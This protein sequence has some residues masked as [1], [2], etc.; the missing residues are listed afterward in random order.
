MRPADIQDIPTVDPETL[1]LQFTPLI[2]KTAKRYT[3]ALTHNN[4]VDE[5]DLIQA[6]RIAILKAQ[7]KYDPD[8]GAS[9]L[10]YA[11]KWIRSA[12]RRTIGYQHDGSLPDLPISLD[13]PLSED[14]SDSGTRLDFVPDPHPT[15]EEEL[16]EEA[17]KR[18]IQTEIRAAVDRLKSSKQRE[19]I[20][21]IWLNGQ[22][23][24]D[25]AANMGI[26]KPAL[27]A[28]DKNGRVALAK[29]WRLRKLAKP[30]FL[31]GIDRFRSTWTS[32]VEAEILWLEKQYDDLFGQGAFAMSKDPPEKERFRAT[33]R[34]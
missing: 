9:F 11:D 2:C 4:A 7:E 33:R 1:I 27:M 14:D 10:S 32:A 23:R 28:L 8:G 21:R 15:R 18:E 13:E 26:K 3:H 22:T 12:M 16:V 6:G 20:Q 24:E 29:D 30:M 31:V 34:R 19:A 5:E 17:E 25:A